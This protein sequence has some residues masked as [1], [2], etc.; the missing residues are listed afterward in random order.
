M[1]KTVYTMERMATAKVFQSINNQAV[2]RPKQ[3]SLTSEEVEIFR[4]G[5]AIIRREKPKSLIRAFELLCD[6]PEPERGDT[7]PQEHKGP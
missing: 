2:R 5:D 7:P 3:F 1:Y 4:R 6:L